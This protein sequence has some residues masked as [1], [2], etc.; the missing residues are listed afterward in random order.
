MAH[1]GT[2]EVTAGLEGPRLHPINADPD[3]SPIGLHVL[4]DDL[5]R[6]R[7]RRPSVR[8]A[9]LEGRST[10]RLGK[11]TFV[12][13]DWPTALDLAAGEIARVREAYGNAAIFGGSY[14]WS[15]AGRFHHAQSQVHRFLNAAGGYVRH[16]DSYSLGAANVILPHVVAPM[17]TLMAMHSSWDMLA[18]HCQLFITFGG[19]PAKNS[20]MN[21]GGVAKHNLRQGVQ[22]MAREGVRI[23]NVGPVADNLEDAQGVE[24]LACRPNTDTAL[25]IALAWVLLTENLHDRQFLDRCTVGFDRFAAYLRGEVDGIVHDPAWAEPICGIPAERITAL[26]RDMAASRTMVNVAWSLQRASHGE[27]P[28]WLVVVL[29]AMVGQIG[30]PGGGFGVGYG[31]ANLVGSDSVRIKGPTLSQGVNSVAEFI[32]VAR[33]A[34]MLLKPGEP[35]TYNGASY[36][37][38]DIK[39]VYW[40]GGAPFHHHQDLNRLQRA[41]QK[42]EAI[43]VNEQYWTPT[44]K[45]AD[46]VF[47][48]TLS[49]ERDDIGSATLEPMMVAMRAA[50]APTGEARDDYDI[51]AD[52]SQRLGCHETFTEGR[53]SEQWLRHLYGEAR[54]VNAAKGIDLPL[55]DQFWEEGLIDFSSRSAPKVMLADFVE[56]P[57]SHPLATPSGRIEIGSSTIEAFDL[58]DCGG[59]P[60]WREPAEWLGSPV[61]ARF[62]LH[63]ISDQP[64]RRLHSQL[65]ASPHSMAGKPGGREPVFIHLDD[66]VKRGIADGDLVCVHNDRGQCLASAILSNAIMPGVVRLS[67]GAWYDPD[68]VTGLEKHGNPNVLTLD[69]P[70][71][72]LSQGC[73]AQTCLVEISVWEGDPPPLTAHQVPPFGGLSS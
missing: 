28:F 8:R 22:A 68:P 21:A 20:Q 14:G 3:P 49:L 19:L 30:T 17:D 7:V 62:P 73:A 46:I 53:T 1:W 15:S 25:M 60:S 51:F 58:I 55:F 11:D 4:S 18:K 5:E 63:L 9:W 40:A 57:A 36:R 42:P 33:I 10:A 32:P 27:Q 6:L 65:D 24:W 61:A 64:A 69:I 31:A 71:S 29:A 70:A 13:L 23:V 59:V 67:T 2:Y 39:L 45:R 48:A 56:N 35:F 50:R 72:S 38:P 12:E 37:Y 66:A 26:A 47:P 52:L 41:W 34:D 43:I 54:T 44:A 16:V